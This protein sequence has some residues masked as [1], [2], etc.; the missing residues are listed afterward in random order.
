MRKPK[1]FDAEKALEYAQSIEFR[2]NAHAELDKFTDHWDA[3]GWKN[4][5]DR[6]AAWRTWIRN[7]KDW[8]RTPSGNVHG[9][10]EKPKYTHDPAITRNLYGPAYGSKLPE[11]AKAS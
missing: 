9:Q 6:Q 5:T 10:P 2:G 4:I 1:S 8:H 7:A 11:K 3:R